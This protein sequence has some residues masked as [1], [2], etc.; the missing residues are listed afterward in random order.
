MSKNVGTIEYTIDAKTGSLLVAEKQVDTATDK[1]ERNFN[2]VDRSV[3]K[4]T[5]TF[6]AVGAALVA[7]KVIAYAQSWG[8]V[9]NQLINNIKSG[10]KLEDVTNRVFNVAQRSRSSLTSTAELYSKLERATRGSG[11]SGREL[12]A[13]TET[14]N[15]SFQVSGASATTT[16]AGIQ[17]LSQAL[18]TGK[19]SGDEFNS[20]MENAPRLAEG[21][22]SSL[23]VTTGALREMAADG[24]ITRN[25]II[26]AVKDMR[27][28]VDTEFQNMAMTTGQ[29]LEVAGN[30]AAKYFG[31]NSVIQSGIS[32]F[33]TTLVTL[34]ENLDAV[35]TAILAMGAAVGGR[36]LGSIITA[37]AQNIKLA[38]AEQAAAKAAAVHAAAESQ[39][40]RANAAAATAAFKAA[41]AKEQQ[42]RASYLAARGTTAE[43]MAL[44]GLR[45]AQAQTATAYGAMKTASATATT[46][47]VASGNAAKAASVGLRALNGVMGILGGPA[48]IAI[49]AAT[50]LI[51]FIA[52][53]KSTEEKAKEA[54]DKMKLLAGTFRDMSVSQLLTELD[55]LT[56]GLKAV[57]E[58]A[59][60]AADEVARLAG[61]KKGLE[62]H[63][64]YIEQTEGKEA[65]DRERAKYAPIMAA[66]EEHTIA[67]NNDAQKQVE[68][69]TAAEK[70]MKAAI[71]YIKKHGSLKGFKAPTL[72][73]LA[74]GGIVSGT[75][76]SGSGGGNGGAGGRSPSK[77]E[78][79]GD[80]GRETAM[81]L[82]PL[83]AA[84]EQMRQDQE[85][86]AA[87][88]Q[89]GKIK[90]DEY[91]AALLASK[92]NYY[93]TK[94]KLTADQIAKEQELKQAEYAAQVSP[95][96]QALGKVDPIQQLQNEWAIR[97][98]MLMDLGATEA[99]IRQ[100]ELAHEQQLLALQW[101][102]WTAQ[103]ETNMLVGDMVDSLASGATNALTGLLN[104]TQSL[105]E[106]FANIGST[107]LNEVCGS[108]A[109]MGADWLREQ[110]MMEATS[111]ATQASA[112]AGTVASMGAIGSAAAPAAAAVST[113]TMGGA[114]GVA[115][116]AL[117]AIMSMASSLFG[118]RRYNGG[119][120]MGGNLYRVGEGNKPEL[121]QSGN[122]QYMIPGENGRVIPNRDIG[123]GGD[124]I[125]NYSITVNTTN[126][127][128]E[129]D[130]R[131]LEATIKRISMAQIRE[132]ATRP[133][134]LIQP[135]R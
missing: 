101:E 96:Q 9:N 52:G 134:G 34:S 36:A 45:V 105:K 55:T 121:F 83:K 27:S 7:R 60:E 106:A 97:K 104:G 21:I 63:F 122:K 93:A 123:G 42:A 78:Q 77:Y 10:E 76:G 132:Q 31:Q 5:R 41:M 126:G 80:Q 26:S 86:L 19:L 70:E 114:A 128:S 46:A 135:R 28:A 68:Q 59:K 50:M 17:Q 11:I 118:G 33:N 62:A 85:A 124:V 51:P 3:S 24:K 74:N 30:N 125:N 37:T 107:I 79:L 95:E 25:V 65:A 89:Q 6:Q 58:N 108:I 92:Q 133:G 32:A 91:Q 48:G 69:M 13:I 109:Q 1:M 47:I 61:S 99:T 14:I 29:A 131:E 98:A 35:T 57:K 71:D 20:V 54:D 117:S 84:K 94:N 2:K 38:A 53:L 49:T 112:T 90:Q 113:A 40:A 4:L 22:A 88:Y 115:M 82:L 73:A 66:T 18:S 102:R 56:E 64:K 130:S 8:D 87:A 110:I 43:A 81:G 120:A 116:S 111:K 75:G 39:T 16:A 44:N 127:W 103:S 100:Q 15:K 72:D 12:A 129:K 67:K 23:G 119:Q